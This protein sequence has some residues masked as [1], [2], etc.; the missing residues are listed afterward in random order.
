MVQRRESGEEIPRWRYAGR[1]DLPSDL[2]L[3]GGLVSEKTFRRGETDDQGSRH[4]RKKKPLILLLGREEKKDDY[5]C[6]RNSR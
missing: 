5:A 4:P 3:R 1:K 6:L 2:E